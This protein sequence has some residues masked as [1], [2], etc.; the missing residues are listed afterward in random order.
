MIIYILNILIGIVIGYS[1]GKLV[2]NSIT[3]IGPNSKD[4]VKNIYKDENGR[5]Y[6]LVPKVYVCPIT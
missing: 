3:Y 1:I 2:F 6:K 4:I 5:C